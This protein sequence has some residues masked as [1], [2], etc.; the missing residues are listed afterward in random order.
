[1]IEADYH[2]KKGII[3]IE[4]PF[5]RAELVPKLVYFLRKFRISF[6]RKSFSH[7]GELFIVNT[8]PSCLREE[9]T[10][11]V[12]YQLGIYVIEVEHEKQPKLPETF[13]ETRVYK[14]LI[15]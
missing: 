2:K 1:M 13:D 9:K 3:L 5:S 4:I 11:T 12:L 10:L 14:R 15:S 6:I 7:F 8:R